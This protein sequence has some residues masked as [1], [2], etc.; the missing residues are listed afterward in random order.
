MQAII[1][2]HNI[3]LLM[4]D[5]CGNLK[6]QRVK[7]GLRVLDG[8]EVAQGVCKVKV[9]CVQNLEVAFRH[10]RTHHLPYS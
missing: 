6:G 4:T 8:G 5:C 1:K 2:T 10:I 9:A 3:K 7:D